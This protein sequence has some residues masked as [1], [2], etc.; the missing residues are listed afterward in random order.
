MVTT[1]EIVEVKAAIMAAEEETEL[2]KRVGNFGLSRRA[3]AEAAIE[4][5]DRQLARRAEQDQP[6]DSVLSAGVRKGRCG[7]RWQ[8][9]AQRGERLA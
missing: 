8:G 1:A 3:M 9:P 5:R 2:A 4:T 7:S 6:P